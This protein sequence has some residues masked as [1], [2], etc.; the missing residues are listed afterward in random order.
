MMTAH[1]TP[2]SIEEVEFLEPGPNDVA[3]DILACGICR[4]DY[5]LFMGLASTPQKPPMVL[6]H[7]VCGQVTWVGDAVTRLQV[8][9]RVIASAVPACFQ[10]PACERGQPN[11]CHFVRTVKSTPRLKRADG[12]LATPLIGLGGFSESSICNAASLVRVDTDLPPDQ[13]CLIGCGVHTG[14][15]AVFNMAKVTPGASVSV[16]GAGGIGLS[17]IQACRISGAA[18]IIAIDPLESKRQAALE[19]GATDVLD[20]TQGNPVELVHEMTHGGTDFSFEV[21]G[22]PELVLQAYEMA[23]RGG[24]VVFIGHVPGDSQITFG[25][26]DLFYEQKIVSSSIYGAGSARHDFPRLIKLVEAGLFNLESLVSQ[27]IKLEEVN[28]AIAALDG[29]SALRTVVIP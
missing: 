20:P 2:M 8:G 16:I 29:G 23:R 22:R 11:L 26:H 17:V 19:L 1:A 25:G 18:R 3:I 21:V 14:T 7:E 13:L 9:D 4:S 24:R 10:C 5:S 27:H 28:D 15:G 12:S 6:G